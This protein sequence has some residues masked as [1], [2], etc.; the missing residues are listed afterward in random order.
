MSDKDLELLKNCD[1]K[2][3][4]AIG[5]LDKIKTNFVYLE[6]ELIETIQEYDERGFSTN[7][8]SRIKWKLESTENK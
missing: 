6:P 5:K 2:V 4:Q 7:C 8:Y 3:V 1:S